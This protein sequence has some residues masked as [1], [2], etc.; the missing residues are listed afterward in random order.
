MVSY[1][2]GGWRGKVLL[3][4]VGDFFVP[5]LFSGTCVEGDQVV[6]GGLKEE[7]VA[8]H[9]HAAIADVNTTPGFPG[10]MPDFAA[11]AS[12]HCPCVVWRREIKSVSYTH[13]TL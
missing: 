8:I 2:D 10:V 4:H 12:I 6:I 5:P 13:L 7:P 1:D 3:L 11:G 9:S